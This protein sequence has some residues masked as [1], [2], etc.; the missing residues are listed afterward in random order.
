LP[1]GEEVIVDMLTAGH[2][3]G[4]SA[5]F[6]HGCYTSS[7]QVVSAVH[8]LGIPLKVLKER[9]HLLARNWRSIC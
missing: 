3:V 6:D 1:E 8:L 9:I 7:A 5:I 4:E 2:I